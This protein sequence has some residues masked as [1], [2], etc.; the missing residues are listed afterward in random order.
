MSNPESETSESDQPASDQHQDMH[1]P[2]NYG[3]L[4]IEDDPE[5]EIDPKKAEEK[6]GDQPVS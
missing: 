2:E 1:D 5:G 6:A 3:G 4:S